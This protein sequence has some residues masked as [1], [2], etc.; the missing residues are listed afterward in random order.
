MEQTER[1]M[2]LGVEQMER[3]AE[4]TERGAEQTEPSS[5][6][7]DLCCLKTEQKF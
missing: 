6:S 2:E 3:R 5:C 7:I 1:G 4:Q